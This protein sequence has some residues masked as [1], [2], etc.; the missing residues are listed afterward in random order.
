MIPL[1]SLNDN[2]M[3]LSEGSRNILNIIAALDIEIWPTSVMIPASYRLAVTIQGHDFEQPGQMQ[4]TQQD[5]SLA[6]K[7]DQNETTMHM[8]LNI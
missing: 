3:N 2:N 1:L 6:V 7:P 4:L 8:I 5:L